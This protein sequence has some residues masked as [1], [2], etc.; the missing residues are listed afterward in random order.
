MLITCSCGPP[1]SS[2]AT[3]RG[4]IVVVGASGVVFVSLYV[5]RAALRRS[6]FTNDVLPTCV[7]NGGS[8]C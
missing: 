8:G 3:S 5:C 1:S 7:T 4:C 6:E 2:T